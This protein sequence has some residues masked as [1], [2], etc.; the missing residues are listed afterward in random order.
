MTDDADLSGLDHESARAYALGFLT[1]LKATERALA[2]AREE[3]GLWAGRASLAV[4]RGMADLA[5]AAEARASDARA[6]VEA[7]EAERAEISAKV[8]R[9]REKLR[10]LKTA[11][12]SVDA[13]LL[14][15]ELQMVTGEAMDPEAAE[16]AGL[17]DAARD[18]DA[19]AAL[20]E[21]KK[22]MEGHS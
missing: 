8:D 17:E 6:R 9:I 21:L 13:D 10:F 15:A 19:D 12:R 20:D 14:L 4:S 18:V 3:E 7:L 2:A 11:E 1:S 22:K 5:A 16:L